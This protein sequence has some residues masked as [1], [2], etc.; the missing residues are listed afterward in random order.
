MTDEAS[1]ARVLDGLHFP[2]ILDIVLGHAPPATLMAI[3]QVCHEWRN[4]IKRLFYHTTVYAWEDV[5][6]PQLHVKFGRSFDAREVICEAPQLLRHC[7]ILDSEPP[8]GN[9]RVNETGILY[10]AFP[11]LT[12]VRVSNCW[13]WKGDPVGVRIL[14][15]ASAAAAHGGCPACYWP[16]SHSV[17]NKPPTTVERF[18]LTTWGEEDKFDRRIPDSFGS[19]TAIF[20]MS[21]DP[22]A[23]SEYLEELWNSFGE[24]A[25]D[26]WFEMKPFVVVNACSLDAHPVWLRGLEGHNAEEGMRQKAIEIVIKDFKYMRFS[27]TDDS[28]DESGNSDSETGSQGSTADSFHTAESDPLALDVD[29][30]GPDSQ[31]LASPAGQPVSS[32]PVSDSQYGSRFVLPS[33]W[34][35]DAPPPP[36]PVSPIHFITLEEYRALVGDLQFAIDT[37]RG[38]VSDPTLAEGHGLR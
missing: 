26:A 21:S 35:W 12:T 34:E 31:D 37:Q 32:V 6:N 19:I 7:Q 10:D 16:S 14:H 15:Y 23:C 18:V 13:E 28:S 38:W 25:A 1:P 2:H 3:S 20:L 11:S 27:D 17:K 33:D 5:E 4:F 36:G 24:L 29:M 8:E 9:R 30:D 22:G